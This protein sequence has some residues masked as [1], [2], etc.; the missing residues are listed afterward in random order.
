[1]ALS[2]ESIW[3]RHAAIFLRGL[4]PIAGI[5]AEHLRERRFGVGNAVGKFR[6]A[7]LGLQHLEIG[8]AGLDGKLAALADADRGQI[9][10]TR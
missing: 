1:M 10:H 4:H 6:L 5:E 8:F 2:S 9:A 7:L 3:T